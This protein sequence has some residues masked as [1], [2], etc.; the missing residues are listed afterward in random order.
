MKIFKYLFLLFPFFFLSNSYAYVN[1]DIAVI[2]IL[3]N[4][5]GKGQKI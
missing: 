2:R 4:T 1:K 3:N 5:A